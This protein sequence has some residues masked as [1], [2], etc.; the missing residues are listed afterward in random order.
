MRKI[1]SKP[2]L[3]AVVT[4][5]TGYV[6]A[7]NIRITGTTVSGSNITFSIAWDNSWYANVAPSNNDAAWVFI[8]YQ[9]CATQLWGHAGLSTIVGDHTAAS[10]LSVETVADGKGVFLRRSA[11]GGGNIGATSVTLK[12]TIPAGTYNYK[13]FGVEMVKV[14]KDTFQIGDGSSYTTY[15]SITIDSTKQAAGI[16]GSILGN[17][18][19]ISITSSFPMG[20]NAFYSMK[21]EVSQQQYV[22]FL[23][24]LQYH[25]QEGRTAA[26]PNA[27]AGTLAI[28]IR[29]SWNG[30][31]IQT[32]GSNS[33]IPAVYACDY[34]AGTYNDVDDAQ[35]KACNYLNW[36]DLSAYLD[37]AALRPMTEMEY[38]KICRGPLGRISSEYPWGTIN[39]TTFGSGNVIN[40]GMATEAVNVIGNGLCNYNNGYGPMRCGFAATGSTGRQSAGAAYYGAMEMGGN[41]MEQTVTT[42]NAA[43]AAYDGI[44]GD[45]AL[46]PTGDANTSNWP[47]PATA[48][49]SG[50]RGGASGSNTYSLY[51]SSR[52]STSS[53]Q[54][55]RNIYTGGRGVR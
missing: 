10:P 52:Y 30:I 14:L 19:G 49:G 48:L 42:S 46:S 34:T 55:V 20:Y 35:N 38:E 6:S 21:Y 24:T 33:A 26:A 5:L 22:D 51:T 40:N 50:Y 32:P 12:M 23:N 27:A 3:I 7:N 45:G 53:V 13:V 18:A 29:S 8:K 37:W 25:Q 15:N 47:D 2:L 54:T 36:G 16:S 11:L 41:I 4:F 31:V 43:G 17:N 44:L 1:I 28:G 9:D 39:I